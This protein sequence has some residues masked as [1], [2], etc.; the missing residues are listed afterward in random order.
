MIVNTEKHI[1]WQCRNLTFQHILLIWYR[2]SLLELKLYENLKQH[3][4]APTGLHDPLSFLFTIL[5]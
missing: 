4:S 2:I 3:F 5:R 1:C